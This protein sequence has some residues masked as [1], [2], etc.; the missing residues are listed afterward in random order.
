[1]RSAPADQPGKRISSFPSTALLSIIGNRTDFI[2]ADLAVPQ[3]RFQE[4]RSGPGHERWTDHRRGG[5]PLGLPLLFGGL[6]MNRSPAPD[7][8][9]ISLARQ[10]GAT[11]REIE[12]F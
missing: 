8:G 2:L 7:F 6:S 3:T 4:L 5:L 1:M 10:A 11:E 9:A 12:H